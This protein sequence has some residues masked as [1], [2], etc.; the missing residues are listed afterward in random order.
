MLTDYHCHILPNIDDGA[1]NAEISLEMAKIMKKQGVERIVA[2]PHFLAHREIS[3]EDFLEKRNVSYSKIKDSL[4]IQNVRLGAEIR[5]EQGISEVPDIEKLAIEGT[6]IILLEFPYRRYEK[7]MSE[8]IYNISAEF[9]LKIM[10]AHVHRYLKFFSKNEII[11]MPLTDAILQINNEAFSEWSQKKLAKR[12]ISQYEDFAFGSDAHNS[13][14]R[15]P[16]WDLI[17]K[18][19]D[20]DIISISDNMLEK[21]AK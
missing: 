12:I 7:W 18:K 17:N 11:D 14:S 15:K 21:Y 9:N 13:D 19:V 2:T 3:V 20:S 4:E 10:L 8:E 16:N 6:N 1:E 5:I